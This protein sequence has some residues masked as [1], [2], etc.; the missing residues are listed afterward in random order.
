MNKV[1]DNSRTIKF[2][3][4][5]YINDFKSFIILERFKLAQCSV[6]HEVN[7]VT[8]LDEVGSSFCFGHYFAGIR[9]QVC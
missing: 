2:W 6:T 1:G 5:L 4:E 8:E 7:V 3:N 9:I